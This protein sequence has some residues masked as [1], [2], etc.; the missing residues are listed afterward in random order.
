VV[1][2]ELELVSPSEI[3][4]K[5]EEESEKSGASVEELALDA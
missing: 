2:L 4:K 1:V 5:L 3:E